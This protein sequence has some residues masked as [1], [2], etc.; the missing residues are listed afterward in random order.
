MRL[1]RSIVAAFATLMVLTASSAGAEERDKSFYQKELESW[2]S[3][4]VEL[5]QLDATKESSQEI[6]RIRNLVSQGQAFL[7]A[8]KLEEI[9]P[10][11]ERSAALAALARARSERIA[12]EA[13]ANEIEAVAQ[14]I[15]AEAQ[16]ARVA[17]AAAEKRY[18]ELEAKGL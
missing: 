12:I 6:E 16:A 7:A 18:E 10:V 11:L 4:V 3:V 8:E 15:E 9:D 17:A 5:Q 13:K 14:Q 2:S 1:H